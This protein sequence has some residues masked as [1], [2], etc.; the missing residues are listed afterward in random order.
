MKR[1]KLKLLTAAAM[2]ATATLAGITAF[3]DTGAADEFS[4]YG[5]GDL[6][7][8]YKFY[9]ENGNEIE[10][11]LIPDRLDSD[12]I[13]SVDKVTLPSY[14]NLK[15]LGRI[16]PTVEDQK[17]TES[18]WA[19]AALGSGESS[20]IT[21]GYA[22][23]SIDFSE[24]HL[25]WF[26]HGPGPSSLT[27]PLNGECVPSHGSAAYANAGVP[28]I[29]A[30]GALSSGVGAHLESEYGHDYMYNGT[31]IPESERY[32]SHAILTNAYMYDVSD[33]QSVKEALMKHGA[34]YLG[35]KTSSQYINHS[36]GGYFSNGQGGGHGVTLIGWDD[37][38]SKENFNASCRPSTDGAWI[39]QN[40]YGT[41]YALDGYMYIS[42]EEAITRFYSLIMAPSDIYSHI[43][44]YDMGIG[45][46]GN[47]MHYLQNSNLLTSA[48]VFDAV[49]NAP[50]I[51]VSFNTRM[52]DVDYTVTVITGITGDSPSSGKIVHTQSGSLD[53]A[54]YH[55][56]NLTKKIPLTEGERFAIAIT[57]DTP[58]FF[59]N[60]SLLETESFITV[61]AA[62]TANTTWL[63]VLA[64]TNQ[65]CNA[66]I[67]A[68]AGDP[69]LVAPTITA[70]E[71][72]ASSVKLTWDKVKGATSYRLYR[73]DTATGTKSMIKAVTTCYATDTTVKAGGRYYYY[74]AAYDST[75]SELGPYSAAKRVT[76]LGAPTIS[77]A[78]IG[79]NSIKL[80]WNSVA[81]ATSYRLY[82]ATSSTG[83]KTLVK[84]VTSTSATDTTAVKG[85]MYYY[86]VAAFDNN[87][88]TL[89]KY[90]ASK[91]AGIL[92]APKITSLSTTASS[93]TVN[94]SSVNGATSYRLYRAN[95]ETGT[96]TLIKAV[97]GT[98]AT[99]TTA[100]SG[101]SYYYFVAAYSNKTSTLSAYSSAKSV[102]VLAVPTIASIDGSSGDVVVNFNAVNGATSYRLYRATSSTGS[103]TLIKAVTGT[104]VTDTTAVDG[105]TYYYFVAAY[106]SNT[107]NMSGYSAAKKSGTLAKPAISSVVRSSDGIAVKWNKVTGATSYRLYRSTTATGEKTL[108]KSLT[109]NIWN[110]TTVLTG[111]SYFYFVAAY[112]NDASVLSQYSDGKGISLLSATTITSAEG[113]SGDVTLT[114]NAVKGA[115]SY[116]LYRSTTPTGT[117]KQIK[118]VT[119]TKVTDTTAVYGTLYYY[120]V[121]PYNSATGTL[122]AY[123]AAKAA[124]A[125][126]IEEL[127][128]PSITS[129]A[130]NDDCSITL[131]WNSVANATSYRLY[132]STTP[133]G[134]KSLVAN[135]TTLSATDTSVSPDNSYYYYVVAYNSPCN[136]FSYYS[137]V[138]AK[139][140]FTTPE[141]YV[142][143]NDDG[144][145]VTISWNKVSQATS[146]RVYRSTSETGAKTLLKAVT[147][148][149]YVDTTLAE[150]TLYYYFVAPYNNSTGTLGSYSDYAAAVI[151]TLPEFTYYTSTSDGV[152]GLQGDPYIT[153]EWTEVPG[154]SWYELYRADY[155]NPSYDELTFIAATS[156]LYA[157]DETVTAGNIYYYFVLAYNEIADCHIFSY[158]IE[159]KSL[160]GIS[161]I[162][163]KETS[164]TAMNVSWAP[165]T[166]ATSYKVYRTT[167]YDGSDL[168]LIVEAKVDMGTY[169][170]TSF[171]NTDLKRYYSYKYYITPYDAETDTYGNTYEEYYDFTGYMYTY[172]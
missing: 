110:D 160:T 74:V 83:T 68:F 132:R 125:G 22:D 40:S 138:A 116:R 25:V 20:L 46:T 107:S 58:H 90:S 127:E 70:S 42:Y 60:R 147:T 14:Y 44:Q 35:F 119:T 65:K 149:S 71:A 31:A 89:S 45:V 28:D 36:T 106:N 113:S 144:T 17:N 97:T 81:G 128:T 69:P 115:T 72:T 16:N 136:K 21:Q 56:I 163:F 59:D 93:V 94:W 150:G 5:T 6:F 30:F 73:A 1:M 11:D 135:V 148:S 54:G 109:G 103:K 43:Y 129:L 133:G 155:S 62:P 37:N 134:T 3:A 143:Y 2:L 64:A 13:I 158:G 39:I 171:T 24:A 145:S 7:V 87:T 120:F 130:V 114:Y 99:D 172:N 12:N 157:T 15:D 121:A 170:S 126:T 49:D 165:V 159:L 137:D 66:C 77:S 124:V 50:L 82:R 19:H 78:T 23:T 166:G 4:E 154:A 153:L 169:T 151:L 34:L 101:S 162:T 108:I 117:K 26:G 146:Y 88:S 47:K 100:K 38:Y 164:Q 27:D 29:S 131:T 85:T 79:T 105:N 104:S 91:Y 8:D 76:A 86:F 33:M 32:V 80:S 18:C 161:D 75:D 9:D 96:K 111:N 102:T 112:N 92:T 10:I 141:A 118:A 61:G 57:A 41:D 55:T 52:A 84:T 122:G 123:S 140:L 152:F 139:T 167:Y 63:T 156:D 53:Y 95:T 48:N 51:A 67:K 142:D 168:S 98:S